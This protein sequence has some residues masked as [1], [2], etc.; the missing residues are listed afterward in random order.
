MVGSA[1]STA[2][3]ERGMSQHPPRRLPHS[4][5]L[6]SAGP[7]SLLHSILS[8]ER[9]FH[10]IAVAKA[11][12]CFR[13]F[14]GSLGPSHPEG[15]RLA[16]RVGFGPPLSPAAPGPRPLGCSSLT[17]PRGE[18]LPRC[19]PSTLPAPS[20]LSLPPGPQSGLCLDITPLEGPFTPWYGFGLFLGHGRHA[21]P[22]LAS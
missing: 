6:T 11:L 7:S 20:L 17:P 19:F 9:L 16:S 13:P 21:Y 5:G 1:P 15:G 10:S 4:Q 8:P 12:P 18:P 3:T 2:V 14:G 22:V